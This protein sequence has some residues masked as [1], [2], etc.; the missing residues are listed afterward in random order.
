MNGQITQLKLGGQSV[1]RIEKTIDHPWQACYN[2]N[3]LYLDANAA[4]NRDKTQM[5]L[6]PLNNKIKIGRARL[7]NDAWIGAKQKFYN[8]YVKTVLAKV[9]ETQVEDK[10]P[11][12]YPVQDI[13][14]LGQGKGID[15]DYDYRDDNSVR[16]VT[17]SVNDQVITRDKLGQITASLE[18]NLTQFQEFQLKNLLKFLT[19][20]YADESVDSITFTSRGTD[21]IRDVFAL[22]YQFAAQTYDG[23]KF[24]TI[25]FDNLRPTNK[26]GDVYCVLR[27]CFC[28]NDD[29]Q[30]FSI[31]F[32]SLPLYVDNESESQF[33]MDKFQFL[34]T[35]SKPI[36]VSTNT[37]NQHDGSDTVQWF[38]ANEFQIKQN[39]VYLLTFQSDKS[40]VMSAETTRLIRVGG[41]TSSTQISNFMRRFNKTFRD[42]DVDPSKYVPKLT[43][44][45]KKPIGVKFK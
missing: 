32:N 8:V 40:S 3:Q 29:W 25:S 35:N 37:I 23:K 19:V 31:Q 38:F 24:N 21:D 22:S 42:S 27:E 13:T 1:K 43:L 17:I 18:T 14:A 15:L 4:D 34:Y 33:T 45:Y 30:A 36:A 11:T 2:Q 26:Q 39:V 16:S 6:D 12:L 41:D 5:Y 44:N 20:E 28:Q 9:D 7:K 10:Q